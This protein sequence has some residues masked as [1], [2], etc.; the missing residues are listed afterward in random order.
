MEW[1]NATIGQNVNIKR[2]IIHPQYQEGLFRN[3][4]A[5]VE[6]S[7]NVTED[8]SQNIRFMELEDSELPIGKAVWAMGWGLQPNGKQ[9]DSLLK[10]D[11]KI[12][13][14]SNCLVHG[15]FVQEMM[16]CIGQGD[17]KDTC[18]GDSGGP[19]VYKI[20]PTDERWIAA[21]IVSFGGSGCGM[22]GVRGTYTKIATYRS[23]VKQ[24]VNISATTYRE[25]EAPSSSGNQIPKNTWLWLILAFVL[26]AHTAVAAT[27]MR[28]C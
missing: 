10:V 17:G 19:V 28:R 16:M 26:F 7:A 15:E 13:E 3:D 22:Q 6:L 9:P 4:I 27:L 8:F 11:I 24:Y 5:L 14:G 21:G 25:T 1:K 23:W 12:V 2:V 20:H 18:A